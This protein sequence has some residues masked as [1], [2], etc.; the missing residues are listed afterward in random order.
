YIFHARDN[1]PCRC[2]GD[3]SF[4]KQIAFQKERAPDNL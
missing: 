3:L 1:V 2:M 4:Y